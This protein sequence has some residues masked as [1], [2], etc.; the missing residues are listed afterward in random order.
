[1]AGGGRPGSGK[2]R[3]ASATCTV[4]RQRLGWGKQW[5]AS[6]GLSL[7]RGR[8]SLWEGAPGSSRLDQQAQKG[9][10]VEKR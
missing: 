6:V 2:W 5:A 8:E 4:Y 3:G 1:M 9:Q 10:A 7:P